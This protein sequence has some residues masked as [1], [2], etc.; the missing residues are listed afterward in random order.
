MI[1]SW[2]QNGEDLKVKSYFGNYI[3]NLL[4]I[5]E[6]DGRTFSNSKLLIDMGWSA[7]L[8]EPSPTAF[9]ALSK[10]YRGVNRVKAI[11]KAITPKNGSYVLME[12]GAH[13]PHG[14]D[15]ALVSSIHKS[16]VDR[17]AKQGVKFAPKEV[18]GITFEQFYDGS[19]FDF[20]TIDAESCD[21]DILQQINLSEVGCKC[22]CIE[23]NSIPALA[24]QYTHYC[25]QFGLKE[26]HRNAENIIFAL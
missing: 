13:V 16:D 3:G 7:Q 18:Q 11:N 23:W 2:S 9:I 26:I 10:E 6:N 1:S 15:I 25:A 21:W 5:G 20:I 8:L 19:K 17:W 14:T 4:S 12:S 22:L 24:K